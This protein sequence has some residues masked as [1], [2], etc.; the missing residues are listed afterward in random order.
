MLYRPQMIE[1]ITD[2]DGNITWE[3]EPVIRNK[4]PYRQSGIDRTPCAR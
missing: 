3:F 1:K 4:L 2:A